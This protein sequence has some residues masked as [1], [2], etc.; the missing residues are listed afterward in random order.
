MPK[1]PASTATQST[2]STEEI[3]WRICQMEERI[4][5][6]DDQLRGLARLLKKFHR[7]KR[8]PR[9]LLTFA[10]QIEQLQRQLPRPTTSI[11]SYLPRPIWNKHMKTTLLLSAILT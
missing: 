3:L 2:N 4:Q 11:S 7:R 1:K 6:H 5:A 10:D 8:H 9:V